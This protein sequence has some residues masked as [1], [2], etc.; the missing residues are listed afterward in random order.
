MTYAGLD[1]GRSEKSLPLKLR[2]DSR[3]HPVF[4]EPDKQ[5]GDKVS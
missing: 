4:L 2:W 1:D 3:T 5:I